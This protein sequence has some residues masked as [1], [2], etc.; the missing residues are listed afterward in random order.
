MH[1]KGNSPNIGILIPEAIAH[2]PIFDYFPIT[3]SMLMFYSLLSEL[4]KGN[5]KEKMGGKNRWCN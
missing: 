1:F 5:V 3:V 4:A 2:H